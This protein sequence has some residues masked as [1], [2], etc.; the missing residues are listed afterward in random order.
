MKPTNFKQAAQ[1][2]IDERWLLISMATTIKLMDA[3]LGET[4]CALCQLQ[5]R[6]RKP[7]DL[8]NCGRCPLR[9]HLKLKE[10]KFGCCIEYEDWYKAMNDDNFPAAHKASLALVKRLK[11][12]AKGKKC[13]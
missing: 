13:D 8:R 12:I 11:G 3:I 1:A 7:S 5:D 4:K 10:L 2:S 9:D 6:R